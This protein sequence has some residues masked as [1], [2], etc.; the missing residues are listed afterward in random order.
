VPAID[1]FLATLRSQQSKRLRQAIGVVVRMIMEQRGWRKTGR[2]GSLGVRAA[3]TGQPS[4]LH[5]SGGL[6][7]W[8]IRAERYERPAGMPYSTVRE[9]CSE[10]EATLAETSPPATGNN[11][12]GHR[13]TSESE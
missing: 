7:F 3:K 5:N 4:A 13:I 11:G 10:Y 9:R 1:Q 12:H 8:F 6:A 2:K